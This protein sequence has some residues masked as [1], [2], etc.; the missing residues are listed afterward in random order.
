MT[1]SRLPFLTLALALVAALLTLSVGPA[2]AQPAPI[3]PEQ[4]PSDQAIAERT[5]E[6][7]AGILE[8]TEARIETVQDKTLTKI[9]ELGD[10]DGVTRVARR[11]ASAISKD[12]ASSVRALRNNAKRA[13]AAINRLEGDPTLIDEVQTAARDAIDDLREARKAAVEAIGDAA[14]LPDPPSTD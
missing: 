14:D 5:L 11:G 9:E 13:T 3:P 7:V 1:A 10:D 6:R 2:V 8:R 12:T 4:Q